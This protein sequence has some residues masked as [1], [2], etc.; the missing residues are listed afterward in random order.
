VLLMRRR[1]RRLLWLRLLLLLLRLL[2]LLQLRLLLGRCRHLRPDHVVEEEEV[3]PA[4][5][6]AG[7]H[8]GRIVHE[9][10]E[11]VRG[12]DAQ[13]AA[14]QEL[15][16]RD[17]A[18]PVELVREHPVDE[19]ARE[20]EEEVDAHVARQRQLHRQVGPE[21]LARRPGAPREAAVCVGA[22]FDADELAAVHRDYPQHRQRSQAV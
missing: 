15:A 11:R 22:V 18:V 3:G 7:G 13:P 4:P 2:R 20:H 9:Q 14:Q 5:P 10:R 21:Q 19:K 6:L 17:A 16:V 8:R 12:E 1:R